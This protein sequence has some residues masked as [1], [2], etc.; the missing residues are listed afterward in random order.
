MPIYTKVKVYSFHTNTE[1]NQDPWEENA[2]TL[3]PKAL[4]FPFPYLHNS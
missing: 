2:K 1:E 3:I 4:F